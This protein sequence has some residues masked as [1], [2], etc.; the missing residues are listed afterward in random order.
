MAMVEAIHGWAAMAGV[1]APWLAMGGGGGSSERGERGKGRGGGE[2]R[3]AAAGGGSARL[4]PVS[5]LLF[6]EEE[7]NCYVR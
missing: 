4:L 1:G 5:V 3:G 2:G 6:R 7:E